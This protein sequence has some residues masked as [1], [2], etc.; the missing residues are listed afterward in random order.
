[1]NQS[2]LEFLLDTD[3]RPAGWTDEHIVCL[4]RLWGNITPQQIEFSRE[5]YG[6]RLRAYSP[7]ER[8]F[9]ADAKIPYLSD[10]IKRI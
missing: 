10:W 2:T 8:Q 1:M 5:W 3:G 6:K 9:I 7:R 4:K